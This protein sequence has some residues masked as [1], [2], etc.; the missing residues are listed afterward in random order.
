MF[1]GLSLPEHGY[2]A[3]NENYDWGQAVGRDGDVLPL[4]PQDRRLGRR[5]RRALNRA[6]RLNPRPGALPLRP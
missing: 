6:S 1:L 4:F 2:H 3:I 5:R